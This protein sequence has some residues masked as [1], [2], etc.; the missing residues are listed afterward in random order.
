MLGTLMIFMQAP[1]R[2]AKLSE[3]NRMASRKG[4]DESMTHLCHGI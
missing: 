4:I 2:A 1:F 3:T